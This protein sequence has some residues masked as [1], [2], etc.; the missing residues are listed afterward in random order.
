MNFEQ[1]LDDAT[2]IKSYD[3]EVEESPTPNPLKSAMVLGMQICLDA[4]AQQ[5]VLLDPLSRVVFGYKAWREFIGAKNESWRG[6][7][8]RPKARDR[9]ARRLRASGDR[10]LG[11]AARRARRVRRG[12][13]GRRLARRDD[14]RVQRRRRR[15]RQGD[16]AGQRRRER[17]HAAFFGRAQRR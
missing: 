6:P 14:A 15:R 2:L 10:A 7:P 5:V 1:N 16:R 8:S 9:R 4:L 17:Q 3:D 12:A 11:T 13:A